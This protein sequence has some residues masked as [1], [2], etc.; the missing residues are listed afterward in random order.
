MLQ[1]GLNN[2][3]SYQKENILQKKSHLFLYWTINYTASFYRYS[4]VIGRFN[5]DKIQPQLIHSMGIS[6]LFPNN[7]ISLALDAKNIFDKQVFDNYAVQK[8]GRALF[9]KFTYRF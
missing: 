2:V 7:H 1:C 8:P 6:Y 4:E 9:V 5:K 3:F